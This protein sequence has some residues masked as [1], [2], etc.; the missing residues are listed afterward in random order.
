MAQIPKKKTNLGRLFK[1]GDVL[2]VGGLFVTVLVMILPIYPSSARRLS[3][4]QHRVVAAHS[5]VDLI[6]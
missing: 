3:R 6:R 2:L 4:D 1:N 5:T